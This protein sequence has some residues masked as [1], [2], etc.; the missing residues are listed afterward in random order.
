MMAIAAAL[1][2]LVLASGTVSA[3]T[4][5]KKSGNIGQYTINEAEGDVSCF[6]GQPGYLEGLVVTPPDI[7]A[8][9]KTPGLDQ[10]QVGWRFVVKSRH[11]G[12]QTTQTYHKSPVFKAYT[13]DL[14]PADLE[15]KELNFLPL[16][17]DTSY[18]VIIKAF[19]YRGDGSIA[20]WAKSR[21]EAHTYEFPVT[22]LSFYPFDS[23]YWIGA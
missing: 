10:Q 2:A 15:F 7:Y 3:A 23:C 11:D 13:T 5:L 21:V 20:G 1:G 17:E 18:F 4:E 9:N 22:H 14:S 16:L 8:R 6:Y 19:W 12:S